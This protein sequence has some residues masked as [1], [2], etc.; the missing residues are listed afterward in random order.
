MGKF[1]KKAWKSVKKIAIPLAIA[2]AVIYTGGAALS[3]AGATAAGATA[4]G[5]ATAAGAKAAVSS[6]ALLSA[7]VGSAAGFSATKIASGLTFSKIASG[8]GTAAKVAQGVSAVSGLLGSS[9]RA[10]K[11][12]VKGNT[13]PG[14]SVAQA[15]EVATTSSAEVEEEARRKRAIAA[16]ATNR[17]STVRAGA[18]ASRPVLGG[19]GLLG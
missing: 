18:L 12:T 5:A 3:A 6:T 4:T 15:S 14:S 19:A 1:I 2:A 10:E 9:G 7:P 8:I 11:I 16:N 17:Q 13:G